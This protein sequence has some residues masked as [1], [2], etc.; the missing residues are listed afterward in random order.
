MYRRRM[1]DDRLLEAA[2]QLADR[3]SPGDL[4]TTLAQITAAAVEVLPEVQLCSITIRHQDGKLTTAAPT[5]E[6]LYDLDAQ[7]YELQE[8]PCYE[9]ATDEQYVVS[10]DLAGDDR[11]PR[12]GAAAAE[13]GIR[14]QIGVRLFESP[15]SHGALNLYSTSTGAFADIESLS[16]LFV[17]QAAQAIAHARE[18]DNLSQALQSR[19]IIGQ[20]VGIVMER[21]GLSDERAFA[22]LQ[23]LSSHR[24]VKL[25]MVAQEFIET[26]GGSPEHG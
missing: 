19:T 20:A 5:D 23:R 18:I 24:N 14:A 4:D 1:S 16:A 15:R 12:Y 17:H 2:R 21:Y 9:A 7:Q 22:F 25:R 26:V 8:G 10:S 13:V 11:F 3:L 6:L